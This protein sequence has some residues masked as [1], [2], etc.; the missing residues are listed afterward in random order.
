MT[1]WVASAGCSPRDDWFLHQYFGYRDYF[2]GQG[3]NFSKDHPLPRQIEQPHRS[4]VYKRLGKNAWTVAFS[5][6]VFGGEGEEPPA[7]WRAGADS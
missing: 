4:M 2:H 3:S 1:A 6:P 7:D 5:V